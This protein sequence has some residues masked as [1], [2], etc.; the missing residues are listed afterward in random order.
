[1][2]QHTLLAHSNRQIGATYCLY[3]IESCLLNPSNAGSG[4]KAVILPVAQREKEAS[5][6]ASHGGILAPLGHQGWQSR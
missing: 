5:R 4:S 2:R 1:M 6:E 3:C